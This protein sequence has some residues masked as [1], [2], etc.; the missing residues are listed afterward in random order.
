MAA[1]P[2]YFFFSR[3][4]LFGFSDRE[5]ENGGCRAVDQS[6]R[7]GG[8]N[9]GGS[10]QSKRASIVGNETV[11]LDTQGQPLNGTA[12]LDESVANINSKRPLP[13]IEK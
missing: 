5:L 8:N 6:Q 10:Q 12:E 13:L 7:S 1:S 9:G 4:F 2:G 3:D 11:M